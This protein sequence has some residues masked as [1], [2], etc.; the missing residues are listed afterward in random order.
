MVGYKNVTPVS[1]KGWPT[2]YK[3]LTFKAKNTLSDQLLSAI[4]TVTTSRNNSKGTIDAKTVQKWMEISYCEDE[5]EDFITK[6][7]MWRGFKRN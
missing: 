7:E 1:K 3:G 6:E 5:K 4:P 2:A